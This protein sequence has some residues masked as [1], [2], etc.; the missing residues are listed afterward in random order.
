MR[1]NFSIAF[2]LAL[3]LFIYLFYRSDKTVINEIF[4]LFFSFDSY[5]S[6]RN[7]IVQNIILSDPVIYS[8]PGGLWVYCATALSHGFYLVLF[9]IKFAVALLPMIF[10]IGL[11]F[12]QLVQISNGRFDVGDVAFY[13]FF[14]L[15]A[16]YF[17][18]AE[19]PE[20][21]ILSPFTIHGFFCLACMLSVYLA[22][23]NQ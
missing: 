19:G 10:A 8:L 7:F 1:R 22:H 16:Y 6:L 9:R 18:E 17:F 23:V 12:C 4:V 21:N 13:I 3:S 11:E 15:L 5:V 20:Q 2:A 14:W